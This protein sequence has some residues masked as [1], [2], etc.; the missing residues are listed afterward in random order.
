VTPAAY[1]RIWQMRHPVPDRIIRLGLVMSGGLCLQWFARHFGGAGE[2]TDEAF[3]GLLAEAAA[4]P[5]GANGVLFLPFLEGAATPYQDSSLTATLHGLRTAHGRGDAVRA[6]IEGVAYNVRDCVELLEHLGTPATEVRLSEGG[7]RSPLWCQVIADVIQRPTVT[8]RERDSSALGAA[9]LAFAA[10]SGRP[11]P[12]LVN[13]LL[14]DIR[15][16]RFE[17]SRELE[18]RYDERYGAYREL[19]E[20]VRGGGVGGRGRGGA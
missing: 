20:R 7:S 15:G 6:I 16:D 9:I 10:F 4:S 14:G 8:L 1:D 5:P 17:P 3:E 12:E 13:A 19:V 2:A 11:L 18:G